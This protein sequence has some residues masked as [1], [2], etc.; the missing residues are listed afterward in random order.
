[1]STREVW[2]PTEAE[3]AEFD[4]RHA[5]ALAD[6]RAEQTAQEACEQFE[7]MSEREI[8]TDEELLA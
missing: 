6:H 2:K 3:R 1:M 4:A 8:P 5:Q 7:Q